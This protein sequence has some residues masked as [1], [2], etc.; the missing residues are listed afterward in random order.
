ME[1]DGQDR[2]PAGIDPAVLDLLVDVQGAVPAGEDE[3]G[4]EEAGH[5]TALPADSGQAEPALRDGE[6]AGVM[7]EH[8]GQP[9]ERGADQDHVLDQGHADLSPAR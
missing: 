6:R 3:H 4:R 8:R 2:R 5:G 7:A 9:D 1:E